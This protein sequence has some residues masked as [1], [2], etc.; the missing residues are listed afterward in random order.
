MD[1]KKVKSFIVPVTIPSNIPPKLY[2]EFG[3]KLMDWYF[4]NS[5]NHQC[6]PFQQFD[7]MIEHDKFY[8]GKPIYDKLIVDLEFVDLNARIVAC[9]FNNEINEYYVSVE[10]SDDSIF[11]PG[12]VFYP[13]FTC[14]NLG[15]E[16][17]H[18]KSIITLDYI[19]KKGSVNAIPSRIKNNNS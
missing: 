14:I 16:D 5:R 6:S 18:I 7:S 17:M 12:G 10:V 4:R 9:D 2:K 13:G 11:T 19:R 3:E 8:S 15:K 1:K